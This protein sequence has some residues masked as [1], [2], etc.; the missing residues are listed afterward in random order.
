MPGSD[1]DIKRIDPRIF[2]GNLFENR[3]DIDRDIA[4]PRGHNWKIDLH[5]IMVE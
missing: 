2:N 3:I 1:T 5:A 4:I